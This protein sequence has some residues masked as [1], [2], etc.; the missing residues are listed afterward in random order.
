MNEAPPQFDSALIV[1]DHHEENYAWENTERGRNTGHLV[2]VDFA[3]PDEILMQKEIEQGLC[4]GGDNPDILALKKI[5]VDALRTILRLLIPPPGGYSKTRWRVAQLR[6][7]VMAHACE[8]DD[9]GNMRL[10]HLAEQLECSRANMSLYALKLC[11]QLGLNKLPS[12]K[13]RETRETFRQSAIA[14]HRRKGHNMSGTTQT[15]KPFA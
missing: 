1:M 5:P 7:A 13:R 8:L 2:P 10:A 12:G 4:D 6:L 11:D 9:I 3:S 14:A 15:R